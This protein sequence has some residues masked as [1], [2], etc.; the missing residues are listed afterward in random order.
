[1]SLIRE[2]PVFVLSAL[3]FFH[4]KVM[5]VCLTHG[6]DSNGSCIGQ[7]TLPNCLLGYILSVFKSKPSFKECMPLRGWTTHPTS[8]SCPNSFHPLSVSCHLTWD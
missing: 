1:M 2:H 3:F 6:G 5:P 7:D 8:R 4:L